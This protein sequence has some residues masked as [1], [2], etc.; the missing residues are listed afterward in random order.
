MSDMGWY[1]DECVGV[2]VANMLDGPEK[3]SGW[4]GNMLNVSRTWFTEE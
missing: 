4:E 2:E 3:I 1:E